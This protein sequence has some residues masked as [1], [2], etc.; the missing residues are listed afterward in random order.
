MSHQTSLSEMSDTQYIL[1]HMQD[2]ITQQIR[3][4]LQSPEEQKNYYQRNYTLPKSSESQ[5]ADWLGDY[6][7]MQSSKFSK[8]ERDNER[9]QNRISQQNFNVH[10]SY[11]PRSVQQL[12]AHQEAPRDFSRRED[13][14]MQI[15]HHPSSSRRRQPQL[16]ASITFEF[17]LPMQ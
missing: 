12:P 9:N 3:P 11:D 8:E 6:Q 2:T 14:F 15:Q 5:N 13:P 4:S 7:H 16:A 1:T 17:Q 10:M